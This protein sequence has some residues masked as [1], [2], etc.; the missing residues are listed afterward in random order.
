MK[1]KNMHKFNT[2]NLNAKLYDDF[3]STENNAK[4][5]ARE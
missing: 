2:L 5:F 1:G 3:E 4:M